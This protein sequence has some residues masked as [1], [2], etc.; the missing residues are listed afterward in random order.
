SEDDTS[1]FDSDVI[2]VNRLAL[3]NKDFAEDMDISRV[4][5]GLWG[6]L[7]NILLLL[8]RISGI[9]TWIF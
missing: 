7:G 3:K 8:K 6:A 5:A 1:K 4:K 9:V 2:T